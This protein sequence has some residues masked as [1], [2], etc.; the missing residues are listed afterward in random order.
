M[1]SSTQTRSSFN[2]PA[3]PHFR[4]WVSRSRHQSEAAEIDRQDLTEQHNSDSRRF[5]DGSRNFQQMGRKKEGLKFTQQR[6]R[7]GG[8]DRSRA[9]AEPGCVVVRQQSQQCAEGQGAELCEGS[10]LNI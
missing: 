10:H 8:G 4:N 6:Q 9:E 3:I 5:C 7:S 1:R 2:P